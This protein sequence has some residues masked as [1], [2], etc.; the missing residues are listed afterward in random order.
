MR[1][2]DDHAAERIGGHVLCLLLRRRLRTHSDHNAGWQHRIKQR[3]SGLFEWREVR[4]VSKI[5]K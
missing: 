4:N 5:I 1:I 3:L 2:A